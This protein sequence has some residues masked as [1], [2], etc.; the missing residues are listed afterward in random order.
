MAN[1]SDNR[2]KG[3]RSDGTPGQ[4]NT[5]QIT[6]RLS[7][8]EFRLVQGRRDRIGHPQ[9]PS[10]PADAAEAIRSAVRATEYTRFWALDSEWP[11][12]LIAQLAVVA[13]DGDMLAEVLYAEVR[14][15]ARPDG[16]L[17]LGTLLERLQTDQ[18]PDVLEEHIAAAAARLVR[19][20]LVAWAPDHDAVFL[21]SGADATEQGVARRGRFEERARQPG[22]P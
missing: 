6:I 13:E 7:P 18:S 2:G 22:A 15:A 21:A 12:P 3:L 8:Y 20:K 10:R 9:D 16:V 5:V 19:E 4:G 11:A 17:A 1:K 14:T